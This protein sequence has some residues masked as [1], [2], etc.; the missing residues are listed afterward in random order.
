VLLDVSEYEKLVATIE[1]FQDVDAA[2]KQID[3]GK[4]ISHAAAR[5]NALERIGK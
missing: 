4:G 1:L 3:A 2:E 5:K